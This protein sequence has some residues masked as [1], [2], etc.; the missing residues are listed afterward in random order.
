MIMN[1]I[2]IDKRICLESKFLDGEIRKHLFNKLKIITQKEC[3]KEY[4]YIV[5]VEK[6]ISILDHEIGRANTD[7]I[8]LVR[9]SAL[10][11]KPESGKKMVGTVCMVYRDGIFITIMGKQKMLIP[12][13]YLTNYKFNDV[14]CC[15]EN[16]NHTIR[17]E[18]EISAIVTAVQYNK[19]NFSCFGS[20]A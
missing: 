9:F 15:Y 7:N 13:S 8:F 18:D 16:D 5:K 2:L 1:S 20:L 11:L 3:T 17:N 10:T 4:G 14:N 12:K 6:I 19:Q